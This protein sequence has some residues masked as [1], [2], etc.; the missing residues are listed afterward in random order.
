MTVAPGGIDDPRRASQP[1]ADQPLSAVEAAQACYDTLVKIPTDQ[2]KVNDDVD[3]RA[4]H[5]R[6][7]Y[8]VHD[9]QVAKFIAQE[10]AKFADT[11]PALMPDAAR[12]FIAEQQAE[13]ERKAAEVRAGL[14]PKSDD[15]AELMRQQAI[16]NRE[17][18]KLDA[19]A[20]KGSVAK[21]AVDA[22][23]NAGDPEELKVFATELPS[24]LQARGVDD[25][26]FLEP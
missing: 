13:A 8:G 7:E 5:L 11:T 12:T 24:Y 17:R 14:S 26:S 15:V 23:A 2:Q 21:A 25:T 10:R 9:D 16:W 18:P 20:D 1:A 3:R 4:E 6:R 19:K 22:I